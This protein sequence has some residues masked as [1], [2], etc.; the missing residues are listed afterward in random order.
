ME[1]L[2]MTLNPTVKIGRWW[3]KNR[4][5]SPLP[6]FLLMIVLPPE[7]E[8]NRAGMVWVA[9]GI[10][11]AEGLRIWA[12]GHAGSATRT[13]GE[14]VKDFVHAGPFRWVRNPLYIANI[15]L[16]TLIG[17]LFGFKILSL[18]VLIYSCVQY[19]FIVRFEEEV[20]GETFPGEY[21]EY[22]KQ[23]PRWFAFTRA[24]Y[25]PSRHPFNLKAAL[26][27]ERSTLWLLTGLTLCVTAKRLLT[28]A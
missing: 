11:L 27:S 16:Y 25:P 9:L 22:R 8:L 24:P 28:G 10:L 6:F 20:L 21:A 2:G 15:A 17:V 19:T 18:V 1:S 3:F 5:V 13:R 4:S 7:F 23:V 12:V 14:T 26:R